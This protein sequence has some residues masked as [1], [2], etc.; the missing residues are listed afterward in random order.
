MSDEQMNREAIASQV[1]ARMFDE[2]LV[3]ALEMAPD[4]S[5]S[6]PVDFAARVAAK[7]PARRTVS[8]T[9][10]HYGRTAMLI[11]AVVLF[12]ALIWVG[13][14]LAGSTM[15]VVVEWFLCAQFLALT[16]WMGTGLWGE[17]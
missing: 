15:G 17:R 8:L 16:V 12:V 5:E 2:R 9:P 6:I 10:R 1:D 14:G 7:V 4:I 3:R 11:S 13:R